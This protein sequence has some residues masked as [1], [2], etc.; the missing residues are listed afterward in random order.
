[1]QLPLRGHLQVFGRMA[2]VPPPSLSPGS[3]GARLFVGLHR[4]PD[5][6]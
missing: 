6:W 1:M 4:T 3:V 2:I 5:T